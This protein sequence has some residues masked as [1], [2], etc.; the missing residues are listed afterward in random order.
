[1]FYLCG[2]FFGGEGGEVEGVGVQRLNC[3]ALGVGGGYFDAF[4]GGEGEGGGK[5]LGDFAAKTLAMDFSHV[6]SNQF[7]SWQAD[8]F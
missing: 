3:D 2:G 6:F 5:G 1:M 8:F 4:F 7:L